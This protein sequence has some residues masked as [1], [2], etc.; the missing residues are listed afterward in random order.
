MI[1]SNF[2]YFTA[3]KSEWKMSVLITSDLSFVKTRKRNQCI[4]RIPAL[5]YPTGIS[6][7]QWIVIFIINQARLPHDCHMLGTC[8]LCARHTILFYTKTCHYI[9]TMFLPTF[10]VSH[11]FQLFHFIHL[12]PSLC[13]TVS[14]CSGSDSHFLPDFFSEVL[15]AQ[16]QSRENPQSCHH[17]SW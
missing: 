10:R 9:P 5:D 17:S 11:F 16:L 1:S 6:E 4:P 7:T 14:F 3:A 15:P 13:Y 8:L 12:S 2:S